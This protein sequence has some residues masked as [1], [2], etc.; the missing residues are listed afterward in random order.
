MKKKICTRAILSLFINTIV[1][2]EPD[3]SGG[4]ESIDI[5]KIIRYSTKSSLEFTRR[6]LYHEEKGDYK[7]A[8]KDYSRA[9][10]LTPNRSELLIKRAKCYDELQQYQPAIQD[11][12]EVLS[13]R[14]YRAEI[15][16]LRGKI[17]TKTSQNNLAEKDFNKAIELN[18]L[19]PDFY[20]DRG[21]F[22]TSL[23]KTEYANR[24]YMA[25]SELYSYTASNF[26]EYK[27]WQD[28]IKE[29]D[30]AIAIDTQNGEYKQQRQE[31]VEALQEEFR[32]AQED[33]EKKKEKKDKLPKEEF[34]R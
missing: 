23:E 31:C 13:M 26:K 30:K 18:P 1:C 16:I 20:I 7:T 4:L 17:Y 14:P 15:Y 34:S 32:K 5:Q 21:D 33:A 6:G 27:K 19:K 3:T 28:A 29:Y 9:L 12:S 8:V 11:L 24:D 10:E 22:F 2:A 25:A